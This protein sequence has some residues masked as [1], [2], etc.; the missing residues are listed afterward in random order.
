VPQKNWPTE[1]PKLGF[2]KTE[3]GKQ[4]GIKDL[5]PLKLSVDIQFEQEQLTRE[6]WIHQE[7]YID[8][9]LAEHDLTSCSTVVTPLDPSFHQILAG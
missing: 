9:L 2:I 1:Y 3:I 4:F 7:M 6:I 8:S 5:G